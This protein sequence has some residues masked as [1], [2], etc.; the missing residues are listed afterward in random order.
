MPH[1]TSFLRGEVQRAKVDLIAE[2]D[3]QFKVL[4]GLIGEK[5]IA[6]GVATKLGDKDSKK[7]KLEG[8][9]MIVEDIYKT[10]GDREEDIKVSVVLVDLEG[11][12]REVYFTNGEN[13]S[14]QHQEDAGR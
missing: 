3:R 5:M 13:I 12:E 11:D 10:P 8:R 9:L 4:D 7:T 14:L 2:I 6:R 1:N